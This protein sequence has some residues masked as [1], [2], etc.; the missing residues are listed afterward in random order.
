[1]LNE[2]PARAIARL[3]SHLGIV[4]AKLD[5]KSATVKS[6]AASNLAL[7]EQIEQLRRAMSAS[8]AASRAV[9]E[10]Q[11]LHDISSGSMCRCGVQASRCEVLQ[12]VRFVEV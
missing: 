3:T 4:Q 2:P 11:E 6:L 10:L 8:S 1:M 9:R 7:K 12:I 5:E